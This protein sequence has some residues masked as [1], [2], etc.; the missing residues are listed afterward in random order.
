MDTYPFNGGTTSCYSAYAGVPLLTLSG[1]SLISRVGRS[2][3]CNLGFDTLAVESYEQYVARALELARDPALLA[4]FRREARAR[5]QQSSMGNGKKFAA[6][7]EAAA[8][9]L[10]QQAQAGTLTNRSTVAPL[11]QALLLQ[12]AELVWYHGHVEGSRRILDLCLRHYPA[13]G[14]AHVLRA[15]QMARMGELE[16]ARSHLVEHLHSLEP[17]A[18]ADAHLLLATIALNLGVPAPVQTALGALTILKAQGHLTP[19][20]LRHARL[21]AA[22]AH[23]G[24]TAQPAKRQ[25]EWGVSMGAPGALRVLVLVPCILEADLQAL[26]QQARSQCT[27]PPG[28][29]I[30]YRRCDPRDRIGAYNTALAESTHDMLVLMQPHLQLYQPALFIE[31]ARALEHADVVGCGGALRWVQK[32]WTLDLPANKAWGLLRPSPVREGMVDMHLAGDFD[33]PLV[34]GAVVLDGKFLAC[35]PAAVRGIELDEALYDSQWL[36][37]EDWTNR[38]HAAGHRL[39]IHR[40]LGLLVAS[41]VDPVHVGITQGQ[42]QLLTRLQLD[43]LA[44]TIRNYDSIN[45]PVPHASAD[46]AALAQFFSA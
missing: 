45:A 32:D 39:L 24:Q 28:W 27:H 9:A 2:I 7:F 16:P 18:A 21:L 5:F 46:V 25:G 41:A 31:L 8:Q 19:T 40:N 38:L 22:A 10:L 13:C 14:A 42:K 11:P 6:E 44:L 3:V 35:K 15:R 43:P 34:P 33:G 29:D 1:Q 20:H 4:T 17:A 30:E 26:E 37:E 36:A 12:R 23:G